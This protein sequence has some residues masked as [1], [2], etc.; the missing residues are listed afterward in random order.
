MDSVAELVQLESTVL[1]EPLQLLLTAQLVTIVP[2]EQVYLKRVKLVRTVMS[3]TSKT[4]LNVNT[5]HQ[6]SIAGRKVLLPLMD[7][8]T[9]TQDSCVMLDQLGQSLL[10][11]SMAQ[12]VQLVHLALQELQ[13]LTSARKASSDLMLVEATRQKIASTATK[14]TSVMRL[15]SQLQSI[16]AQRAIIARSQPQTQR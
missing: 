12:G 9:A 8:Q 6:A 13:L 1:R 15:A 5:V 10:M 14:A 11:E 4:L 16:N 7:F 2:A 3:L